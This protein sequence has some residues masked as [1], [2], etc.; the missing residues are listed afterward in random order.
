MHD[1]THA[2]RRLSLKTLLAGAL[3]AALV[4]PSVWAGYGDK[5]CP[6]ET[7]ECLDKLTEKIRSKG[8][9]GLETEK[10]KTGGYQVV[11]VAADGPAAGAGLQAGDVL[12]ALDG[13]KLAPENKE[14]LMKIK[15][16]MTPGSAVNYVVLRGGTKLQV[17]VTLTEMP[18][19]EVAEAVGRHMVTQHA[20]SKVASLD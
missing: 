1:S 11:S 18:E 8:W 17:A 2:T 6:A 12:V 5:K 7:Q 10:A 15:K 20:Q 3:V 19:S 13:V 4:A 9:A 14:K 16:G